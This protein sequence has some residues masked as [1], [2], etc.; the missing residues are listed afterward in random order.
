MAGGTVFLAWAR[1][2]QVWGLERQQLQLPTGDQRTTSISPC[3]G[4]FF[5]RN[6]YFRFDWFGHPEVCVHDSFALDLDSSSSS[7]LI[8]ILQ[9][10]PSA[11]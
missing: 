11:L 8:D 2:I 9:E 7:P 6:N 3:H 4:P 5:S 10:L 1:L